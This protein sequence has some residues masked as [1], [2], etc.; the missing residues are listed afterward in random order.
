MT[1]ENREWLIP[2]YFDKSEKIVV[3]KSVQCGV[4]EFL[5]V[6]TMARTLENKSILYVLPSLEVRNDFVNNRIDRQTKEISFYRQGSRGTD[7]VGMKHF[8]GGTIKFVGSNVAMAFREYPAQALVVDELDMCDKK[9][10]VYSI[11]RMSAAYQLTKIMPRQVLVSNPTVPGHGISLEYEA[12]NKMK[13]LVKCGHCNQ[14]QSLDWFA[15]VVAREGDK[16]YKLLSSG[17]VDISLP[18]NG[19]EDIPILCRHC[20]KPLDRFGKGEWVAEHPD[21]TVHGYHV[22]KLM[23]AQTT[24]RALWEDFSESLY[25]QTRL[26]HFYNSELGIPYSGGGDSFSFEDFL[27]CQSDYLMPLRSNGTVAGVDVGNLLHVHISELV[28]GKRHK[29]FIGHVQSFEDLSSLL[30][31][32]YNCQLFVM[33]ARPEIHKAREFVQKQLKGFLCEYTKSERITSMKVNYDQRIVQVDRTASLDEAHAS[34]LLNMVEIPGNWRDLDDGNFVKQMMA[35]SRIF[36]EKRKPPAFI[37]TEGG[38]PD[39]HQ[40]ADNYELIAAKLGGL[41]AAPIMFRG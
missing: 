36:D 5:I 32:K 27:R 33:D 4:S 15:N 26:Q 39:H 11:D 34:Y 22:S 9:N 23:T 13:W 6:W 37:W 25:D 8:W 40:H 7:N 12:S 41:G 18:E 35:A 31:Q 29:V 28:G 2:L 24:I 20:Y 3:Q 14:S 10:I 38:E 19:G 17:V 21:N 1:F 16:E 30:F